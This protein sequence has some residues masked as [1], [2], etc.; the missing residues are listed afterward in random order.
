M[1]HQSKSYSEELARQMLKL[2]EERISILE[3]DAEKAKADG[4]EGKAKM[5]HAASMF[6][7][8][9][10]CGCED[11]LA[12][13]EKMPMYEIRKCEMARKVPQDW[14]PQSVAEEIEKK[15]NFDE[16]S[17]T[18][19]MIMYQQVAARKKSANVVKEG[20]AAE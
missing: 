12:A 17:T 8:G 6:H 15:E 9:F 14:T 18:L 7:R 20:A 1:Q 11:Q 3:E 16:G 5:L 19:R 10:K 13:I 2:T 4:D